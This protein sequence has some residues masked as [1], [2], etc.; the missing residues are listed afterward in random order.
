MLNS[1]GSMLNG[2][3]QHVAAAG[4][5]VSNWA[6]ALGIDTL[7]YRAMATCASGAAAF[8]IWNGALCTMPSTIA[9]QR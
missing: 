4:T 9:D 1:Q 3:S 2:R 8:F 6:W 5:L 7:P